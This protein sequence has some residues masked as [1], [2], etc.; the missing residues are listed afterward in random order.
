VHLVVKAVSEQGVRLNI[1]KATLRE[2]R[3]DFA[4]HLRE[5]GVEANATERG[6]GLRPEAGL[7]KLSDTRQSV[8]QGWQG[9]ADALDAQGERAYA[10]LIRG[11]VAKMP[12]VRTEKQWIA[13][14]LLRS[15][16]RVRA[17][18]APVLTR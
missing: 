18:E 14:Q 8:V 11:F 1:R 7:T 16:K 17:I 4:A 15:V 6:G 13:D 10:S 2:W 9:M 12:P 5:L 3:R